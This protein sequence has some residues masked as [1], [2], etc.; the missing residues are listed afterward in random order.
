MKN[1]ILTSLAILALFT[2][3]ADAETVDYSDRGIADDAIAHAIRAP[4]PPSVTEAI[5]GVRQKYSLDSIEELN[6]AGNTICLGGAAQLIVFSKECPHLKRLSFASDRIY[7]SRDEGDY[8]TFEN[9]LLDLLRRE[10]FEEV[11]VRGNDIANSSWMAHMTTK[12]DEK[13][14][15]KITWRN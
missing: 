1:K 12:L 10:N 7:D 14:I 11:D 6:F 9:S 2:S 4:R 5:A 13:S 3:T 15:R 8:R